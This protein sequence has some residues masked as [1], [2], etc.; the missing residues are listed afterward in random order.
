MKS[1]TMQLLPDH[2]TPEL[3]KAAPGILASLI[4]LRW[5]NGTPL[6]RVGAFLGGASGS[7]YLTD[8]L[9][10]LAGMESHGGAM[11][12]LIGLFSMALAHKVFGTIDSLDLS[13]RVNEWLTRRGW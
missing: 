4:A 2:V 13:R 7:Y 10:T 6:Q 5:I 3:A 1:S 8:W 9:A 11:S 12:W